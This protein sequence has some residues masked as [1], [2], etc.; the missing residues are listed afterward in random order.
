[1]ASKSK[2]KAAKPAKPT[3]V[4]D[5]RRPRSAAAIL[6]LLNDGGNP[7]KGKVTPQEYL[8]MHAAFAD[9]SGPG[10]VLY[11]P[12]LAQVAAAGSGKVAV[13]GRGKSQPADWNESQLG[14]WSSVTD[15]DGKIKSGDKIN[16][17]RLHHSR[18]LTKRALPDALVT[19]DGVGT[20]VLG[21]D[22]I[23]GQTTGCYSFIV[24][25]LKAAAFGGNSQVSK[26]VGLINA[27]ACIETLEHGGEIVWPSLTAID[28]GYAVKG[29]N[30]LTHDQ[31]SKAVETG[32]VGGITFEALDETIIGAPI[33]VSKLVTAVKAAMSKAG[34]KR[35]GD[36]KTAWDRFGYESDDDA[37]AAVETNI[38]TLTRYDPRSLGCFGFRSVQCGMPI[39]TCF[40]DDGGTKLV[41]MTI[42]NRL[43]IDFAENQWDAKA[44]NKPAEAPKVTKPKAAPK[45]KAKAKSKGKGKRKAVET[46]ATDPADGAAAPPV[47]ETTPADPAPVT[48]ADVDAE[49]A[50][51]AAE[52]VAS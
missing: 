6:A 51:N 36:D 15:D 37:R 39:F 33:S 1:M 22:G 35:E 8:K 18:N 24:D 32:Q 5:M 46:V 21:H 47:E 4:V 50:V 30:R 34:T 10:I 45:P 42:G 3:T 11:Q 9:G 41:N 7:N 23:N 17:V 40:S 29:G 31:I 43:P 52:A 19:V 48:A 27:D 49:D 28:W 44:R 26:L 13:C 14:K 16:P 2:A 20:L 12:G 38:T 25:A